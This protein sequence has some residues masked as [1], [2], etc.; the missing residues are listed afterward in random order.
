MAKRKHT[1][2]TEFAVCLAACIRHGLAEQASLYVQYPKPT[3]EEWA[4]CLAE[5]R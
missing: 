4:Q 1:P 2:Y 5:V 3:K